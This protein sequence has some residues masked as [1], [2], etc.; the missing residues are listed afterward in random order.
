MIGSHEQ[1]RYVARMGFVVRKYPFRCFGP[2]NE[3]EGNG[4]GA[5]TNY[6]IP[7]KSCSNMLTHVRHNLTHPYV[8]KA[9]ECYL[10][11]LFR[12]VF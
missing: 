12:L 8:S 10:K 1:P 9:I 3:Y 6:P 7:S 4:G 11:S 2:A 5:H